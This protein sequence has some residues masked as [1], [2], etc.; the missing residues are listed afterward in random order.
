MSPDQVGGRLLNAYSL[1][2]TTIRIVPYGGA[3]G[4]FV[5]VATRPVPSMIA[6]RIAVNGVGRSVSAVSIFPDIIASR[7]GPIRATIVTPVGCPSTAIGV[8]SLQSVGLLMG[9]RNGSSHPAALIARAICC[10]KAIES[11]SS[12]KYKI[13]TL[14]CGA[15]WRALTNADQLRLRG[16]K[17]LMRNSASAVLAF[18]FAASHS[19]ARYHSFAPDSLLQ[20]SSVTGR[21]DE[22]GDTPLPIPQR[23]LLPRVCRS[24]S[25]RYLVCLARLGVRLFPCR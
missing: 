18:A 21:S 16:S 3:C 14:L 10:A 7:S 15:L 1:G 2:A 11:K 9:P 23:H 24:R 25:A 5:H 4:P 19:L 17:R 8:D 13:S 20:G 12:A 22:N 6:R